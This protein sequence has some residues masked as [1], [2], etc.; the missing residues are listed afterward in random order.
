MV[1]YT[2]G[3]IYVT[4]IQIAEIYAG[5]R[6]PERTRT[7]L[8]FEATLKVPLD[9]EIG[10]TAGDFIRK[11]GKLHGVAIADALIAAASVKYHL[12]LWTLNKRH[13]PMI[14]KKQLI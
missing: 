1:K 2:K 4:S 13:Y 7:E 10:I 11:Y 6:E 5:L 9:E 8:F 14:P 12:R 3:Q